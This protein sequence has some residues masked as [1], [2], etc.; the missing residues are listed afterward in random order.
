[1]SLQL[2]L[3][4]SYCLKDDFYN[5][6]NSNW[7]KE[8]PIPN[9]LQRWSNFNVLSE[10]NKIKVKDLLDKLKF[11]NDNELNNLKILYTQGMNL[12]IINSETPYQQTK[13]YITRLQNCKTKDELK[14]EIFNLHILYGLKMPFHFGSSSDY[15]NSSKNILHIFG[16]GL[17]LPDRD[18]YF[19]EE[20]K[21]I[22]EEYLLFI[23]EYLDLFN[24]KFNEKTIYN[25]EK[26]LAKVTYTKVERRDPNKINNPVN[27]EKLEKLKSIPIKKFFDSLVDINPGKINLS[28][29][30]F[31]QE[32]EKL[33]N[34]LDLESWINYYI[35]MFLLSISQFLNEKVYKCKFKFYG[36]LLSGTPDMT[37]RWKRIVGNCNSMLGTIVGKLFVKKYFPESSKKIAINMV[38]FIKEEL[39]TRLL[40]ND[41]MEEKTKEKA[42][43]KLDKIRTKVGYPD[44]F[45]DYSKLDLSKNV[46]YLENNLRCLKYEEELDWKR[47]YKDKDLNEWFMNPHTVNAYYSPTNNEI[48]F[49]AGIL[50]PPFFSENY[51]AALN[52]GGI[53]CVIGHEITHGFDDKGRQFDSTGN[54]K[55]WWTE[56]D[57]E[58]YKKK[59]EK[60]RDQYGDYK[61]EGKNVNGELTLGENIA[62]LG[63]VSI[64]YYSFLR[65]LGENKKY[66]KVLE[67][68]TPYQRFFLNYARIW[69]S[70][71]RK[72]E[73]LNKLITDPHSPTI[74]RVNGVL[75]NLEEFYFNFG[76]KEGD[77]MYKS[78]DERNSVW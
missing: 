13:I 31:I 6:V 75:T 76:I 78:K 20:K 51:D 37:D 7:I 43:E 36:T 11:S 30:I 4:K 35:Y 69:R 34:K 33:W 38:N 47:L 3:D 58:K 16:G 2:N 57:A 48:V 14:N 55:D 44:V 19:L 1:M 24:L 54:L 32:Y 49:P 17:G 68:Y 70:N 72:K 8:N 25:I 29:P 28:N 73:I 15:N 39:K 50:Q 60:I 9:D 77:K 22:R 52:F 67:G 71:T 62:D 59:T 53:G 23:K 5:Y 46:S 45:K 56:N 64:S 41:W 65:Y 18:Y 21:K 66:D 61:I 10:E 27:Y 12:D 42:V 26:K 63:G 40:N 74:F